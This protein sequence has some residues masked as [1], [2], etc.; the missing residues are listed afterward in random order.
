VA[1]PGFED[2]ILQLSAMIDKVGWAMMHVVPTE[3]DPERTV[4]F[5]Y[6]VGYDPERYP[7][8][9]LARS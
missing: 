1:V 5:P 9:L 6:T 4:P 7:Q 2:V 3:E 8:P